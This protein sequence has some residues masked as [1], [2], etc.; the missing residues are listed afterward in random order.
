MAVKIRLQRHG[1]GKRPFY[2]IV[3]A[4]SRNRRDGK[5]IDRIGDYN[6]LTVPASINLNFDKAYKWVM[7]GAEPTDTCL[8][9]LS[10]KGVMFKKHLSRGVKKGAM[11]QEDADT[12]LAAWIEAKNATVVS[13]SD[14]LVK[15]AVDKKAAKVAEEAKK[16]AEKDAEK[17]ALLV[18]AVEEAAPVAEE[19]A[20][21]AEETA[22]VAEETAADAP[23]VDEAPVAEAPVVAEAQAEEVQVEEAPVAEAP[24]EESSEAA[25]TEE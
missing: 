13:Q 21:V 25:P 2:H 17:A 19:A 15:T 9:I 18:P 22:P 7:E 20:P 5:F 3:V 1:R 23:I 11:T 14:S 16:R 8:R 24:A 12:K 4:D 6:P 10:H